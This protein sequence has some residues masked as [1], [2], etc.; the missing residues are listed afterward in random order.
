M[1]DED[2]MALADDC[3][4]AAKCMEDTGAFPTGQSVLRDAARALLDAHADAKAAVALVLE[5]AA[6]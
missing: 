4:L 2:V 3:I 1:T 5:R 6:A